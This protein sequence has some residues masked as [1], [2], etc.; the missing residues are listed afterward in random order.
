MGAK[1]GT[2]ASELAPQ[3]W[4]NLSP[5]KRLYGRA[6]CPLDQFKEVYKCRK[7]KEIKIVFGMQRIEKADSTH[8]ISSYI[9]RGS[10]PISHRPGCFQGSRRPLCHATLVA[11]GFALPWSRRLD[12]Q[13]L[14]PILEV[15]GDLVRLGA[16]RGGAVEGAE[17]A[18]GRLPYAHASDQRCRLPPPASSD[19]RCSNLDFLQD[20]CSGCLEFRRF[21]S[22]TGGEVG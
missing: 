19:E 7:E 11:H 17:E 3:Q 8:G 16:E 5:H 2:A 4:Q 14:L 15:P 22:E 12:L 9:S 13:Q 1:E 18:E 20:L 10:Y 6:P 21:V